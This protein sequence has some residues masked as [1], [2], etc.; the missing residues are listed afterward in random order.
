MQRCRINRLQRSGGG[1]SSTFASNIEVESCA[2][3]SKR[4]HPRS[5]LIIVVVPIL[6]ESWEVRTKLIC[7]AGGIN[8]VWLRVFGIGVKITRVTFAQDC[9]PV[10]RLNLP[11]IDLI[12]I[13]ALK[14]WVILDIRSSASQVAVSLC[15]IRSQ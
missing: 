10:W 1:G 6:S 14:P 11:R 13:N 7:L 9:R 15:E 2:T 12:P 8:T 3:A 5:L 4:P